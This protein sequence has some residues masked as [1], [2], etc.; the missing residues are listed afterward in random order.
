VAGIA[1]WH[2]YNGDMESTL[3][4]LGVTSEQVAELCRRSGIRRLT[5]FGSALRQ[6]FGADSDV[7]LVVEFEPGQRVGLRF[8][9]VKRE[10]ESL[11]GR[12]VDLLSREHIREAYR[13]EILSSAEDVYVAA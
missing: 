11:L 9:D 12:P 2:L 10:F 7:D 1:P 3:A 6:D 13:H 5:V 8:F 4:R